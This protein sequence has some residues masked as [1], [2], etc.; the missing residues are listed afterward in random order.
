M[1]FQPGNFKLVTFAAGLAAL[2]ACVAAHAQPVSNPSEN[3]SRQAADPSSDQALE[4]V[5]VTAD[6]LDPDD[7]R[8]LHG[9]SSATKTALPLK[10]IPQ[11]VDVIEV[12][13]F[14]V[15]GI[16]D[17]SVMLDGTPGID[18]AYDTRGDGIT[19]RGF[20][21]SSGDIY[22]DGVRASGQFRRSTANV[23]RIEVLKGP[24]S[25]LYGRGSGG[26]IVNLISKQASFDAVSSIGLRAGS[27]GNAGATLDINRV[28]NPYTVVRLTADREQ[29]DSFRSGIQNKNMMV[30][31]SILFDDK[32]GL[33]WLGQYTSDSVWRRPDRAPSYDNLPSDV[34]YRTA[35]AHPDDFIEDKMQ[36]WRSVLS[37]DFAND[38]SVKWTSVL[39]EASQDFDHLYAGSYCRSNST[40]A[41]TGKRCTAPGKLTFTRAWQETDNRTFNNALDLNGKLRT[42]PFTHDVL[43]GVEYVAERRNPSLATSLTD[44]RMAYTAPIDVYDPVWST[45]KAA[46]GAATTVNRHRADSQAL[47]FQDLV[48]LSEQW[49]LLMGAR[50]DRFDFKT[51]N[52]LTDQARAY[53]GSSMSPR[54]GIVWQPLPAHS[55]YASYSKN[56][57]PYG[58]RGLLGV[59]VAATSVYDEKPQYARQFE[60][61]TKSDWLEGRLSTQVSLYSL[62]LY[63]IRYQPDA[64]NA[65]YTWGVRGR[66]RSRGLE[67][68]MTGRFAQDWYIRTGFGVQAAKVTEDVMTPIN[69]GKYKPGVARNNGS[70]FIRYAPSG[71]W[72]GEVGATHR[73]AIY[74][75]IDNLTERSGYTRWDASVGWRAMPWTVTLAITNLSDKRYWRSSSMPGAPRGMLLSGTYLF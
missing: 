50:Y 66:E 71:H 46:H 39:H 49:K 25:V 3:A 23:E 8:P 21:A 59:A 42:G 12:S 36:M 34:S 35:Y 19:I 44:Q 54:A 47:Y 72:Y 58:G 24:A 65:P 18:T 48:G 30:S 56:F 28:I 60:I 37:Y 32:R 52:V 61:G 7:A 13:K 62:E 11:T 17:L 20:D 63:N 64:V 15:Y 14:K 67:A 26:G 70:V 73:S 4:A 74:N 1:L 16:N 55:F 68:S 29:G 43:V 5:T 53:S 45:P 22:R 33:R 40:L 69:V 10:D 6:A 31:P 38:W 2:S 27:W 51:K 41:S 57:S 9:V 75:A